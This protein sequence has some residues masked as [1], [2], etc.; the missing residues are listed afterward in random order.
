MD[1]TTLHPSLI[2]LLGAL[3]VIFTRGWLRSVVTLIAPALAFWQIVTLPEG[4]HLPWDRFA[5]SIGTLEWLRVD[6]L[7][8]LFGIVF[9]I[10]AVGA[11]LFAFYVKKSQQHVA[12][13]VYVAGAIGCA[14]AGD[15]ISLYVFWESM[16]VSSTFILLSRQTDLARAAAFRYVLIHLF[17]G[18]LFL[19]GLLITVAAPG[20]SIAFDGFDFS[21]QQNAGTWLILIGMLVNAAM[22][23][24]S[25]WLSESYPAATV[26]GGVI[27]SAYTTKTAIYALVRGYAGWEPLVWIG[28]IMAIGGVIYAFLEHDMRRI[29]AYSV[30]NQLGFMICGVGLGTDLA[31]NGAASHAFACIFYTSLL[32]MAAGAVLY[33]T[34]KSHVWE[35]GGVAS[36]MPLTA[37]MALVGAFAIMALPGFSGFTTK[38]MIIYEAHH[39]DRFWPWLLLEIASAGA[40]FHAGL[41]M[42]YLV[43]FRRNKALA[44]V[45]EAPPTMLAAMTLMAGLCLV[46]GCVPE[47]LYSLL[48]TTVKYQAFTAEHVVLQLQLLVFAGMAFFLLLPVFKRARAHTVDFDILYRR[49]AQGFYAGMDRSLNGAN[50]AVAAFVQGRLVKEVCH[51]FEAGASRL[52]CYLMTPVWMMQG[53]SRDEMGEERARLFKRAR[54]GAFPIGLTALFAAFFLALLSILVLIAGQA[55]V[56]AGQGGGH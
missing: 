27:L 43:F 18:L 44:P 52:A 23:P 24:F 19:A 21:T 14:F 20:G 50:A 54:R 12:A 3:L 31:I 1:W 28:C 7:S 53:L 32:W 11:F 41:K 42:P 38:T 37:A 13:L 16:A 55:T 30:I 2:L 22:P 15:L 56:H 40:V 29:L 6:S 17:G 47:T 5:D 33:R 9:T 26:T 4:M 25:A 49:A 45:K 34:K 8:R 39:G 46:I 10:N 36:S 35:L 48:P 51:F